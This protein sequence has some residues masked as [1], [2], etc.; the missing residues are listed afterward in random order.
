MKSNNLKALI[1]TLFGLATTLPNL[2]AS[3]LAPGQMAAPDVFTSVAGFTQLASTG[4]I[5]VN[6]APGTS[7]NATY[8]EVVGTDSNNMLCGVAGQCLT[9]LL[10]VSNSGPGVIERI[11]TANF[12]S[13]LTDV[14]INTGAGIPGII[15]ATVDRSAS[16]DVIG[17]NFNT[18]STNIETGQNSIVLE[19]MTNATA[20]TA[21]TVSVQDGFAGF[22]AGFAPVVAPEPGSMALLGTAL[23]GLGLFTKKFRKSC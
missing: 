17:F 5:T 13:F 14:G 2:S 23:V 15:P 1:V 9:F 3:M 8:M 21:G 6:P 18:G 19:I 10:G 16:G 12:G 11:S 7:F 20:F 4:Y 22:G